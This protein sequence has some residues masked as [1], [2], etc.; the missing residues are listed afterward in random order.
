MIRW[1]ILE[2]ALYKC[3][4]FC[5]SLI[6]ELIYQWRNQISLY[7]LPFR[8]TMEKLETVDGLTGLT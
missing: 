4:L 8:C 5:L 2:S 6:G 1:Y 7:I 3:G